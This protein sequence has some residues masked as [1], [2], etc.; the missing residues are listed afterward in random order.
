M[1]EALTQNQIDEL[2]RRMRAGELEEPKP[3]DKNKEKLYDFS[4]PKKFTKDQL[5]FLSNLYEN[6]TRVIP[7]Y[8]TGI[9]RSIC[10]VNV[11]QIEEQRY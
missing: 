4:S 3:E 5:N 6:F 10:E 2:L 8:F 7:S 1:A 11:V 9:L